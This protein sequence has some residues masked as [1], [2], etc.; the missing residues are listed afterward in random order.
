MKPD[1]RRK[2]LT[3]R[4][5]EAASRGSLLGIAAECWPTI[6]PESAAKK[7]SHAL[8]AGP[9]DDYSPPWQLLD[10]IAQNDPETLLRCLCAELGFEAPKRLPEADARSLER[11]ADAY[12]EVRDRL[13]DID[14]ML[15]EVRAARRRA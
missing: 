5:F 14:R 7:A 8:G 9:N 3:R 10:G 13:S 12:D 11:I 2:S 6:S 15:G 4:A 1:A